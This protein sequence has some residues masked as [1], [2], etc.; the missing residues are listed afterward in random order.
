[1]YKLKYV[2]K[3]IT[4]SI[5]RGMY[6]ECAER[7]IWNKV[8]PNNSIGL[9]GDVLN[10]IF[11]MIYELY[12]HFNVCMLCH[13]SKRVRFFTGEATITLSQDSETV[14]GR[15]AICIFHITEK[16]LQTVGIIMS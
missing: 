6:E 11:L 7:L 13:M 3:Y 12:E 16:C 4:R 8:Y 2:F 14:R 5:V 15:Y 1:M 10:T 9:Q